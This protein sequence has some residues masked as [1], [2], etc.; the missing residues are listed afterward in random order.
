MN[1]STLVTAD[2]IG[3]VFE[4]IEQML[5]TLLPVLVGFIAVRKGLSFL[6]GTL[7]RA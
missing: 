3:G 4:G 1:W 2:T 5:P 7:R 6:L